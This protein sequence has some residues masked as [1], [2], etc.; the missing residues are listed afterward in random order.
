MAEGL[1][2]LGRV[3]QDGMK[4]RAAAGNSSFRRKPTLEEAW[5]EAELQVATLRAEA[6]ADPGAG[7]KRQQAARQRVA[8]ERAERIEA[9]LSQLPRIAAVKKAKDR[10]KAR[11]S[12]TDPEARFMKMA[13]GGFRPALNVQ[14][15]TTTD[16]QVITGVEVTNSGG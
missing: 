10:E 8:R 12:T 1:V 2:T 6:E 16:S 5:K 4:V 7:A 3:A 14:L 11:A 9:A 15:A 13:D